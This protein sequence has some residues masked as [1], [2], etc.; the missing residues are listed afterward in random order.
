MRRIA[1]GVQYDGTPWNGYQ[2][3][4]ARNTVQDK[5]EEA[6]ARFACTPI[7]T[8]CAGRTDRGV[9]AT[10]QVVHFDTELVRAEQSWVRG[11]NAFLPDS[12]TVRWAHE[13][14][15][16]DGDEFHARFAARSRTYHYVLYNHPQPAALLHGRAGWTFRPLDEHRMREAAQH[17]IGT[18]DFSAFRSSDC[19]A[20]SPIK[21]MHEISVERKG[22]IIVFTLRASAFLHHMVRN[23]VGCLVFI[24]TGRNEPG[25]MAEVLAGRNRD[26]AAP[27][28][29][30]DGLYL[31]KI[32]YD[33]KW[34]L[35]Q[36]PRSPLP[37]F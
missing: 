17:L 22:D 21:Q 25:W 4:P 26:L 15:V 3:Q 20:K 24:G 32:E 6:L 1:L 10:E 19:Q 30:P 23:I 36:E 29:M 16:L 37:W 31:A 34:G 27:T 11:T 18:H 2:K 33:A 5:L 9:H 12:I 7:A 13:L 35:P 28:F 14:P 8:T